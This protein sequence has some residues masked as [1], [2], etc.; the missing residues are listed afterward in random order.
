MKAALLEKYGGEDAVKI[1][2]VDRPEPAANEVQVE[3]CSASL[4]PFDYKLREGIMKENIHI[5]FP[6]VLGG[7]VSGTISALGDGVSEFSIGDK[8]YGLANATKQGSLA[9]YTVVSISQL[10]MIPEVDYDTAAGL[11]L[12]ACSA[13]QALHDHLQLASGQKILIH[14]GGGGIGSLAIQ[15][16]KFAG[17]YVATTLSARDKEFAEKLGAD[18]TIDY[19]TEDF[20]KLVKNY[21]SV[22]DTVGGETFEKS[23][24][25][26]RPGG[27]IVSMSAGP[28]HELDAKYDITSLH[29]STQASSERLE[30]IT[31]LVNDHALTLNIDKVFNLDQAAEALE[32]LKSGHPKGKVIV[33]VK[34]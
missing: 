7:D 11:P 26:L 18:K 5:N 33:R 20:T 23:Y 13:Y 15:L 29:Q 28:N 14:G 10:A 21:D 2:N 31:K 22:F 6:L 12:A 17:A 1:G 3:V 16:A 8:V 32:Y 4:N 27:K 24:L 9:E 34:S 25:V 30:A 19:A